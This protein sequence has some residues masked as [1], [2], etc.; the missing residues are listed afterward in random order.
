LRIIVQ[1]TASAGATLQQIW[2]SG[3]FHGVIMP[4]TPIGSFTSRVLPS[5]L[6]GSKSGSNLRASSKWTMPSGTC[7]AAAS[8]TGAPISSVTASARSFDRRCI[9]AMIAS[10]RSS[11]SAFDVR[12][13]RPNARRA[14]ATARLTSATSPRLIHP[15][16]SSVAGLITSSG[17]ARLGATHAPSM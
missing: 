2:L 11:R 14:A 4:T 6:L 10:S 5:S 12:L 3:Q 15:A 16:T 8:P 9:S 7:A 1:P 17:L 13:Y